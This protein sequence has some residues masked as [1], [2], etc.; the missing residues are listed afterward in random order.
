MPK[1]EPSSTL[2]EPPL[3]LESSMEMGSAVRIRRSSRMT[4][5][6]VMA[7]LLM[8]LLL[9][10][11]GVARGRVLLSEM[12]KQEAASVEAPGEVKSVRVVASGAER[13][14][15]N[16]ALPPDRVFTMA[17]GPSRKGAGH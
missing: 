9:A 12:S 4:N 1:A 8:T 16:R 14:E 17:S 2:E 7:M 15:S 10:D 13:G 11:S 6:L 3:M 5:R